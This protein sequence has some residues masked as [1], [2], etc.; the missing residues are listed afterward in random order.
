MSKEY[1][2]VKDKDYYMLLTE[3]DDNRFTVCINHIAIKRPSIVV[4]SEKEA[5]NLIDWYNKRKKET[6]NED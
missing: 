1:W 4:V 5:A 6:S 2:I 3:D